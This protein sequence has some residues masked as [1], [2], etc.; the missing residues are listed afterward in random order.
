M[1][2]FRQK[3]IATVQASAR[4]SKAYS[5]KLMEMAEREES[6]AARVPAGAGVAKVN[7][8]ILMAMAE[9]Q[10]SA[11][12]RYAGIAAQLTAQPEGQSVT[13]LTESFC[14]MSREQNELMENL[15]NIF[16]ATHETPPDPDES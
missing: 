7:I 13:S 10:E 3:L 14:D 6:F 16:A 8:A 9:L 15:M 5:A 12:S 11:G 4:S 2:P 1:H